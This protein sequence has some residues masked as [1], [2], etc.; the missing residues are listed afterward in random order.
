MIKK[1]AILLSIT[2]STAVVI[3]LALF[4]RSSDNSTVD[5]K[6]L[7]TTEK[8]SSTIANNDA[9]IAAPS[10]VQE[11][12]PGPA[13]TVAQYL[14]DNLT[15]KSAN[16][17][18]LLTS[19]TSLKVVNRPL[20]NLRKLIESDEQG[21]FLNPIYSPDGLQIM[22]TR[23]GYQGIYLVPSSGG[24]PEKICDDN[25]YFAKWTPEGLIEVRNTENELRLYDLDGTLLSTG[26]FDPKQ[27]AAFTD[28]DVIYM[29]SKNGEAPKA[30]T[31]SNDRYIA[32]TP[33]PD[34]DAV[35]YM[36][37][38]SGLY[39]ADP[40]NL[41]EPIFLGSGGSNVQWTN[42][43]NGFLFEQSRDDGHTYVESDI[44]YFD[45]ASGE[46]QNLTSEFN[47]VG[48]N[49]TIGPNGTSVAFEVD[50]AIYHGEIP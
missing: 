9:S 12:V 10:Q 30:I 8:V 17:H 37:M 18:P 50:G 4:I 33:A 5:D 40:N 3:G 39:Y 36:G 1:P 11:V 38:Y 44:Y 48:L 34:G 6:N 24:I 31:D 13:A 23:T 28:N 16:S 32:P 35:V 46:K 42:Q 45:I 43:G 7:P 15:L 14:P 49:P 2:I 47:G 20:K 22:L 26:T 19:G 41:S 29:H 27:E 21:G 25:A